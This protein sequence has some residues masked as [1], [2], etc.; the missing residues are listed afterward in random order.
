MR[1]SRKDLASL[2][3]DAESFTETSNLAGLLGFKRCYPI[4]FMTETTE[5]SSPNFR[6]NKLMTSIKEILH[7][8]DMIS[9]EEIKVI[10]DQ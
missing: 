4:I 1:L 5:A 10:Q 9:P 7:E 3:K 8:G 6:V 2:L